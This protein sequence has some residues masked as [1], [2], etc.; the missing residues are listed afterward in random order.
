MGRV[1]FVTGASGFVGRHLIEELA[2]HEWKVRALV[3]TSSATER[4]REIGAEL[5][6][7]TLA[8]ASVLARCIEGSDTVFHLAAVTAA[9]TE[10]EYVATN[11]TG[12]R[13]LVDAVQRAK[14]PP[15]ALV[16][17]SSYAA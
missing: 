12:T 9:K 16:Y 1:A 13:A 3:R 14:A 4:L 17:L 2:A 15:R 7:G 10:E 11:A 6:V 5:H 8:D